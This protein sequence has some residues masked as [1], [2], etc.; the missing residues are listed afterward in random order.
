MPVWICLGLP[1]Q[2]VVNLLEDYGDDP[3]DRYP[4]RWGGRA[5]HERA[6]SMVNLTRGQT[7]DR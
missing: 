4:S 5:V 7:R 6:S 2:K 3:S 1:T